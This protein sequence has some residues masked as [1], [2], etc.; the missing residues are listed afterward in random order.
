MKGAAMSEHT[1]PTEVIENDEDEINPEEYPN[2]TNCLDCG[3]WHSISAI[4]CPECGRMIQPLVVTVDRQG[5]PWTIGWGVL[6][7]GAI[8]ATIT[9]IFWVIV[10]A[11]FGVAR[12]TR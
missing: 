10:I 2:L 9:I 5:W 4:F 11:L 3:N 12:A 1:A 8:S 7:A 6:A